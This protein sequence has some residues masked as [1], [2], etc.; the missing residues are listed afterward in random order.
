MTKTGIVGL[1]DDSDVVNRAGLTILADLGE[2]PA[3]LGYVPSFKRGGNV[4]DYED[5]SNGLGA[6]LTYDSGVDS[7]VRLTNS[8][9]A[10]RGVACA[11]CCGAGA[12]DEAS[13]YKYLPVPENTSLG[14][15]TWF[16]VGS[17]RGQIVIRLLFYTAAAWVQWAIRY[18]FYTY[19]LAYYNSAGS[20]TTFASLHLP[21]TYP[22][23]F[24][25][26]KL[27]LDLASYE[28]NRLYLNE[29]KYDL[30]GK[31]GQV[32]ASTEARKLEA[33]IVLSYSTPITGLCVVDNMLLTQGEELAVC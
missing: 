33:G 11:L 22:T 9:V 17:T 27:V 32:V 5:F 14:F 3:R 31:T 20:Y 13:V 7:Y 8:P 4:L 30:Q 6:V 16:T 10:T 29:W 28:Y 18:N 12:T 15:E 24:N 19:A 2:L 23:L 1:R 21:N 26:F 25:R